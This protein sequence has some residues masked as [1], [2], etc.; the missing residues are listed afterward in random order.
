MY[1]AVSVQDTNGIRNKVC[2]GGG[3]DAVLGQTEDRHLVTILA[4][5]LVLEKVHEAGRRWLHFAECSLTFL[6]YCV[7]RGARRA[8]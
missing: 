1:D 8:G 6:E 4:A 3:L 5:Q 2:V 7:F